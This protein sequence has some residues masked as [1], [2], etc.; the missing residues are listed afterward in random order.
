MSNPN[1]ENIYYNIIDTRDRFF[2]F[3]ENRVN[4]I[5]DNPSK[6][7]CGL[8][9]AY[10]PLTDLPIM[11]FKDNFYELK[12]TVENIDYIQTLEFIDNGRSA[13]YNK[14]SIWNIQE[15]ID[16]TNKAFVDCLAQVPAGPNK[17]DNPVYITFDTNTKTFNINVPEEYLPTEKSVLFAFNKNLSLLYSGFSYFREQ[18]FDTFNYVLTR[19]DII[20][21]VVVYNQSYSTLSNFQELE[22]LTLTSN[23]PVNPQNLSEQNDNFQKILYIFQISNDELS[24]R[25]PLQIDVDH[26]QWQSLDST[27]QLRNVSASLVWTAKDGTEYRFYNSGSFNPISFKLLFRKIK[28]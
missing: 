27:Y 24:N 9:R 8:V 18:L 12:L 4:N 16:I 6:Y 2:T 1:S 26:I 20:N 15:F 3:A 5:L 19:I 13:P 23:I 22:K 17:P 7:E 21:N 28:Y 25:T 10:I 14:N 11:F